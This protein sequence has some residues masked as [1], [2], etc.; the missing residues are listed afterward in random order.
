MHYLK[1]LACA[2]SLASAGVFASPKQSTSQSAVN[3]YIGT[4]AYANQAYA[5]K[6]DETIQY[7]TKK[8]D[9][10]NAARTRTIQKI[11]TFAWVS[12]NKDVASIKGLVQEALTAQLLT[13][14]KQ[15]LQLVVYNLPDRDCSASASDGEFHLSDDGLNKYKAFI[16]CDFLAA[17]AA[18]LST[19]QAKKINVVVILE[20]D[21]LGNVVTNLG[22]E[23]CTNAAPAYK[24]GIAYAIAKFQLPNL[25]IYLDAAHGGWL[26]WDGNL[27]PAAEVFAEVLQNAQ[28]ITHGATVRGLSINVSNYNQY[29]SVVRENFTEWSN[30]WDEFHYVNSLTPHL[31]TAGYPAH[32][33]VDQGRAGKGAIRTDWGQWCNIAGA[34]FGTKPTA[35][36]SVLNN[37]NV[38]AIVWVKPGGESDGTSDPSA[39]RFDA[40]CVSPVSQVPAPEAGS[41]FNAYVVNLVKNADPPLQLTYF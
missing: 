3:P 17:I 10:V 5:K 30:S 27:E 19:P 38:D 26:G 6:L 34:G 23:K 32:F 4:V 1:F 37:T 35:S 18:Q 25:S 15:V 7:F 11:P 41:W 24:A 9:F 21:S 31:Q 29:V 13:R 39:A 22:V 16:D 14:Q 33:I 20:P 36:Q 40:N 8:F 2:L 12:A 28:N